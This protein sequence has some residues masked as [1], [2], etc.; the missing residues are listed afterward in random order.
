MAKA[1]KIRTVRDVLRHQITRVLALGAAMVLLL[2]FI[3]GCSVSRPI[4][5][6]CEVSLGTTTFSFDQGA[7]PS[8]LGLFSKYLITPGDVLDVL[9]QI[10]RTKVDKFPITLYHTISVKFVDLPK[11]NET[12]EVLPNG[13]IILPYLGKVDVLEKTPSELRDELKKRYS[14][15]LQD[16]EIYVTVPGFNARIE[17]LRGDLH[18]STRGLS[19][20][21]TVRPDGYATFPLI[22]DYIVAKKTIQEVRAML[23]GHYKEYLPGLD[24]SL[25]LHEQS[26]SVIYLVGE[27]ARPGAYKIDK[28][29]AVF[30]ALTLAGGHTSNAELRNVVVFR[31]HKEKWIARSLNLKDVTQLKRCSSFFYLK[32]GDII[33]VS[34]TR[35]ASLAQLMRQISEITLFRG[36]SF[37]IGDSVDWIGPNED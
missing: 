7:Y 15:I 34:K 1:V 22:G 9:Y 25:F 12:Q 37:G 2:V 33:F 24:V 26:G 31:A 19:K 16:P 35:I 8:D 36:W 14:S 17:Q 4:Q 23:Q 13:T 6:D 3:Q 29:I 5:R 18:T 28:P 32:P 20:L 30:Q 10:R 11:L 27:I 21:T